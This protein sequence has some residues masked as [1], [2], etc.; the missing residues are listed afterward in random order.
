VWNLVGSSVSE[1]AGFHAYEPM[2]LGG[3]AVAAGDL[4]GDGVAELVTAAGA[5]GRSQVRV[6]SL[7]SGG[8]VEIASAHAYG[9]A[10]DGGVA[11]AVGDLTGDGSP[12]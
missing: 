3:V 10:F 9:P 2:F 5:G 1:I 8:P 7:T 6:W 4:T 11:V 12:S